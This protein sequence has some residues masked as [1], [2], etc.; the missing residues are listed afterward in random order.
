M[1]IVKL[2]KILTFTFSD[3]RFKNTG[4]GS[5]LFGDHTRGCTSA[6]EEIIYT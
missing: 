1:I 6:G 5:L 3:A 2:P 4:R